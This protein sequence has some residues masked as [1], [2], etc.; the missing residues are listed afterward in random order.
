M[1]RSRSA[2]LARDFYGKL[3]HAAEVTAVGELASLFVR[4]PT[5]SDDA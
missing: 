4:E 2:R 3:I 1:T 5:R